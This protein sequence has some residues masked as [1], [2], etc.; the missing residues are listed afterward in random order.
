[1][2]QTHGA[3]KPEQSKPALPE[4]GARAPDLVGFTSRPA[5]EASL[6]CPAPSPATCPWIALVLL[7]EGL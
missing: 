6:P 2:P 1:M 4:D 7:P 5:I 3:V